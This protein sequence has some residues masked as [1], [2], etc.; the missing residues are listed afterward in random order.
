METEN[1]VREPNTKFPNVK[2]YSMF[3]NPCALRG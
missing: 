3:R 1:P 2:A